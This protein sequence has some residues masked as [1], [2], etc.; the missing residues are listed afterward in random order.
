MAE[1]ANQAAAKLKLNSSIKINPSQVDGSLD[2]ISGIVGTGIG[3][4]N[5]LTKFG[6]SLITLSENIDDST[7]LNKF[8]RTVQSF[9]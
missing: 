3:D 4:S 9:M 8:L 5:I 1:I 2:L 7:T 6:S